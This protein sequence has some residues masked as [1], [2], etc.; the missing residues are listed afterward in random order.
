MDSKNK[1]F[2]ER[3]EKRAPSIVERDSINQAVETGQLVIDSLFPIGR[4]QRQLII[5]DKKTGKTTIALDLILSQ[6]INKNNLY[7]NLKK[8]LFSVLISV[9]QKQ[10]DVLNIL[11][12]FEH[13][14]LQ[15]TTS[16]VLASASNA[17]PLQYIAPFV[18]CT[19]GEFFRNNGL[20]AVAVYD[21]LSK[22]AIA[23]RQLAL[24]LRRPPGREAFP[25][26]I[27]YLH[28][29][30]LERAGR[31]AAK[32]GGGSL[33]A[34]PVVETQAG[35]ISAYIPTNIISIT[36]GQLFLDYELFSKGHRPAIHTGLSVS[37]IGSSAQSK[38]MKQAVG[39]FKLLVAQ[40]K[41]LERFESFA[42]DLDQ[43]IRNDILRGK[44]L[45]TFLKQFQHVVYPILNQVFLISFSINLELEDLE[46]LTA[47]DYGFYFKDLIRFIFSDEHAL[48]NAS[49][50]SIAKISYFSYIIKLHVSKMLCLTKS[51][52]ASIKKASNLFKVKLKHVISKIISKN[53]NLFKS[54]W[55][56]HNLNENLVVGFLVNKLIS[57]SNDKITFI[58]TVFAENLYG[59]YYSP[60]ILT[61]YSFNYWTST[62]FY[63]FFVSLNFILNRNLDFLFITELNSVDSDTSFYNVLCKDALVCDLVAP[64]INLNDL[65]FYQDLINLDFIVELLSFTGFE[66]FLES[67]INTQLI[68]LYFYDL[69]I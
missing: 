11:L 9:G 14:G 35:D 32:Y 23:Y 7:L 22:H 15:N 40:L 29:R 55:L 4:G 59:I 46:G 69:S 16:I 62:F 66:N 50:V 12:F 3:I 49:N 58:N 52:S 67:R 18:G 17:A 65:D 33:T 34:F 5:G 57:L 45:T 28:A 48:I 54:F 36:D 10:A 44:V 47:A 2:R 24:L 20:S 51:I 61:E 25:S 37:R 27:F 68:L 42:S 31:L 19:L 26:D 21:D 63:P 8:N 60:I 56:F 38:I 64:F 43:T 39:P 6:Q 53:Y 13:Y 41:Q 1:I 30:L